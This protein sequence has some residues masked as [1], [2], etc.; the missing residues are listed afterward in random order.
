MIGYP[1]IAIEYWTNMGNIINVETN[2]VEIKHHPY[3]FVNIT[4]M[5]ANE[6]NRKW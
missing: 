6:T 3:L 1:S 2:F 5:H 4:T